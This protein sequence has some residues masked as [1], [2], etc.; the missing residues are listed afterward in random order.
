[1]YP[2]SRGTRLYFHALYGK[3]VYWPLSQVFSLKVGKHVDSKSWAIPDVS[4]LQEVVT[5]SVVAHDS[6]S[7]TQVVEAGISGSQGRL[8]LQRKF[9]ASRAPGSMRHCL[10]KWKQYKKRSGSCHITPLGSQMKIWWLGGWDNMPRRVLMISSGWSWTVHSLASASKVD[11]HTARSEPFCFNLYFASFCVSNASGQVKFVTI[12]L[13]L[14][15]LLGFV[16]L[17]HPTVAMLGSSCARA[18]GTT[19]KGF[20]LV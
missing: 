15:W 17:W 3:R 1:M 14:G 11:H 16:L 18:H 10:W 4:S 8:Q 6:N 19:P 7:S 20:I 13:S 2:D 9:K 12:P 5:P